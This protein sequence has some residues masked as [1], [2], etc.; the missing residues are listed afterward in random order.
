[1]IWTNNLGVYVGLGDLTVGG[2]VIYRDNEV[3]YTQIVNVSI[4]GSLVCDGNSSSPE[5]TNTTV[6]GRTTDQCSVL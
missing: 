5:I 2:N 6:R 4:H 3:G 1:M